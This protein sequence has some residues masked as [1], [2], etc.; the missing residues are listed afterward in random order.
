MKKLVLSIIFTCLTLSIAYSQ[1]LG[2]GLKCFLSNNHN[3]K[4]EN[5]LFAPRFCIE[6]HQNKEYLSLLMRVDR[7]C[8]LKF[9]EKYDCIFGTKTGRVVTV[10][11]NVNQVEKFVKEKDI[12]DV[13][14]SR[15]V[16]G[17]HLKNATMDLQVKQVW[18]GMDLNQAYT[19]KDVLIGIADWGID[20]THPT[21]YDTLGEEYRIVAA[22]DQF[23]LNGPH[24]D[25]FD[26]G[27]EIIGKES[28]IFAAHDTAN[29]LDTGYHATHVGGICA[30]S[31]AGTDYIGV[32]PQANL[33]FCTFIPDE[34]HYI[35]C[36]HWMKQ[37]AKKMNK[38]L[39]INN[40]WGVYSFGYLDGT[41]TLDEF[42]NTMSEEDS[43]VFVISAG[44]NGDAYFH[45][46]ADFN[47]SQIDTVRSEIEFNLPKPYTNDYWGQ[48]IS[49]QGE[50]GAVFSSKL[51]FYNYYWQKVGETPLLQSDGSVCKE[52]VFLTANNDSIIY[53][54]SSRDTLGKKTFVD[55]EVR[56]SNYTGNSGHIVLVITAD[57]GVVHAWN[58]NRRSKAVGNTGFKFKQTFEGYTMGDNEYG[59]SEPA[60][61]EKAITVAAYKYFPNAS[62]SEIASFS[63]RGPNMTS[64]WKPEIAAPGYS[65]IS[66]IS[67]FSNTAPPASKTVTFEGK[68]YG[69]GAA[70]G[71][72]MSGPMVTGLVALILQ[73]NPN[74]SSEE[75]K[76]I[77]LQT[78]RQDNDT[79]QCPNNTWGFG[80]I[81]AYEAV[82]MAERKVGIIT[83]QDESLTIFPNP[84]KDILYMEGVSNDSKISVSDVMGRN[85]E[86]KHLN[87]EAL[88][89]RT[90]TSGVYILNIEDKGVVKKIKF[91]KK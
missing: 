80:K 69:F 7:D 31:G 41:S 20:Y 40:S 12:I 6:K 75:V 16:G 43:I 29:Q 73:A 82:K 86:V 44:N 74:L 26:Y 35:D 32:A 49:L 48:A 60:L 15:M 5:E 91:I 34:A 58:V 46:K 3:V 23:R 24:P 8:D 84:A 59:V 28:L 77:V 54:G 72:S 83:T 18:E 81:N 19:G 39:V 10:K 76:Q 65:I 30:G 37:V 21:F 17:E 14:T 79:K 63:S 51:E 22:W 85:L 9:L 52:T 27:T 36:C 56:Q 67:S 64:Y 87:T 33:L 38:R 61:A 68:E 62:R 88:D 71:T 53:R 50:N 11:V 57:N 90:L 89:V 47:Q 66:S 70:S 42:I 13:E 25:G 78:A 1:Q 2:S 55:W 4:G 45:I